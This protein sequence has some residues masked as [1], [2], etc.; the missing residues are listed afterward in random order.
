M[1]AIRRGDMQAFTNDDSIIVTEI[2]E[3]P[4][5]RILF[6]FLAA[7]TLSGCIDL[8]AKVHDF[9]IENGIRRVRSHVRP[10]F[11]RILNKHG[12]RSRTIGVE[13][14]IGD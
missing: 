1:E 11:A 12:W 5:E 14:I 10:G 4:R 6:V 9:C 13:Y 2:A 3:T 7:G 8:Q